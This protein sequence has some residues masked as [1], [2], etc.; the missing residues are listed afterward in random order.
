MVFPY[1]VSVHG[2]P[3]PCCHVTILYLVTSQGLGTTHHLE[4]VQTS[5]PCLCYCPGP[6]THAHTHTSR[7]SLFT[8]HSAPPLIPAPASYPRVSL[9]GDGRNSLVPYGVHGRRLL[10]LAVSAPRLAHAVAHLPSR[11]S[12]GYGLSPPSTNVYLPRSLSS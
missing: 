4:C 7:F 6:S 1:I 8:P 11:S 2:T 10:P 12:V 3:N 9:R 5:L